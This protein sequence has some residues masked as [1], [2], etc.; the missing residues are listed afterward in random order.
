MQT[1]GFS[2]KKLL[3]VKDGKD[4]YKLFD[5]CID[6]C[7][8]AIRI[9][10]FFYEKATAYDKGTFR[11]LDP[12]DTYFERETSNAYYIRFNNC[13]SMA[14]KEDFPF[15]AFKA[16]KKDFII[17]DA[18][19]NSG[20][21]NSFIFEFKKYLNDTKYKGTVIIT[22]DNYSFSSGELWHDFGTIDV[23]FKT[24]LVG[25][26]SGGMQRFGGAVY[27]N[28]ELD[29][30]IYAGRQAMDGLIP[31]NWLGEG[32]GYE[33]QIWA[34]TETIKATLEGMGVDLEDIVFQ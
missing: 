3:S 28:P 18:R 12:L 26:H 32:K 19:S 8:F 16:A 10:D 15:A 24:V 2:Q 29:M 22:Q 17:L 20:G 30:F 25:T 27:D 1:K 6:D 5:K 21:D 13:T 11:S 4:F 33:P 31:A 9:R 14:Y 7:H 23:K 34:T